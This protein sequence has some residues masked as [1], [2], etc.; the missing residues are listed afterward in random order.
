[1]LFKV[2]GFI[3][4]CVVTVAPDLVSFGRVEFVTGLSRKSC[5]DVKRTVSVPKSPIK[6]ACQQ[7]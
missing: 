6:G 5:V 7:V 3:V 1:M 4:Q 2:R